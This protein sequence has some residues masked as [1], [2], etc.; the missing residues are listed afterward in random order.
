MSRP[1]EPRPTQTGQ[2]NPAC[3]GP[4]SQNER[5]VRGF[6][7]SGKDPGRGLIGK[8]GQFRLSVALPCG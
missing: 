5:G 2:G 6:R 8:M 4:S 7:E 3:W 1:N